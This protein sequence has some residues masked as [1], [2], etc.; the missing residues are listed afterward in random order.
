M[1]MRSLSRVALPVSL[2]L[3]VPALGCGGSVASEQVASAESATTRAPVAQ[4]AQGPLKVVGDALGDVPLTASQRTQIEKLAAD[5]QARHADASAAHK[6]LMLTIAAQVDAGA[7]DRQ[8]LQPKLDAVT[9]ALVKAQPADR[10]SFEQ[11]HALLSA[12]QR[13]AFVDALTA[14]IGDPEEK[15]HGAHPLKQWAED[16]KLTDDQ[17]T[18]I[19][20]ALHDKFHGAHA[21]VGHAEGGE[22]PWAG[23]HHGAKVLAAFKQDRFVMDEVAP[24]KDLSQMASKMSEHFLGLAE[25]VLPLLT[26]EQRSLA[27]SKIREKANATGSAIGSPL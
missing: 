18:Q 9:A 2:A 24:P 1:L 23:D 26:P 10:A 21:A 13:A 19:R 20:A 27:A 4:S 8:A 25:T 22:L 14:R 17:R 6:D 12:D 7:I 3:A 11:L 16:L 5:A 15:M